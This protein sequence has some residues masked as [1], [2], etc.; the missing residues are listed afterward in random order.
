MRCSKFV[1]LEMFDELLVDDLESRTKKVRSF[2]AFT[3]NLILVD[4]DLLFGH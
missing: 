1:G 2:S 4:L 3:G